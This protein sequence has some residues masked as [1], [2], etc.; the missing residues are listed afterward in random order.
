MFDSSLREKR[1]GK[2][3]FIQQFL[4]ILLYL[5]TQFLEFIEFENPK[6]S[7]KINIHPKYPGS[8]LSRF[9]QP[10]PGVFNISKV[11]FCWL[12]AL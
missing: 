3:F 12:W 4:L 11:N 1:K 2:V 7:I 6:S 10:S 8:V 5:G 9:K